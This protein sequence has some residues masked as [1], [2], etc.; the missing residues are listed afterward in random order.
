MESGGVGGVGGRE[1]RQKGSKIGEVSAVSWKRCSWVTHMVNISMTLSAYCG[2]CEWEEEKEY[3]TGVRR[4]F[5]YLGVLV[6]LSSSSFV[7]AW[8]SNI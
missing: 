3:E 2:A 1:R 8:C 7:I 5:L 4:H 6:A